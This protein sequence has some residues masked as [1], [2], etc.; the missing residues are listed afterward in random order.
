MGKRATDRTRASIRGE[1][2]KMKTIIKLGFT[3][4]ELDGRAKER[5]L[6]NHRYINVELGEWWDFD[7]LTGFSAAEGEKYGFTSDSEWDDLLEYDKMYFDT[8][9]GSYLQFVNPRFRN[10]EQARKFL[11]IDPELWQLAQYA[12]YFDVKGYSRDGD[13]V[14]RWN[15]PYGLDENGNEITEWT[16]AEQVQ[17]DR[18]SERF[19]DKRAD[20]LRIL[21]D[22][23]EG[24]QS[25]E[26]VADTLQANDYLFDSNGYDID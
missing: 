10:P 17:L 11:G 26:S 6:D 25:D 8:G 21:R 23:C 4:D 18:A 1:T 12:Y 14:L 3:I 2:T 16:K 7:G 22:E 24:L 19:D 20:C 5:A 15:D 13:T 9:R